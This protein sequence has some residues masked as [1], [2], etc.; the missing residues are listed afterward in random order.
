MAEQAERSAWFIA[1]ARPDRPLPRTA[2]PL[3]REKATDVCSAASARSQHM[4]RNRL[5]AGPL[6]ALEIFL[7][8]PRPGL[9]RWTFSTLARRLGR[10]VLAELHHDGSCVLA[11]NLSWRALPREDEP[12][13]QTTELLVSADA[14]GA[15]CRDTFTLAQE[16]GRHLGVDSTLTVT[17]GIAAAEVAPLTPVITDYG[18]LREIAEDARR[19]RRIQPVTSLISPADEDDLLQA[20]TQ[21]MFTD[22]IHQFG[23]NAYL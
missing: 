8:Y 22:L 2:P 14:V 16:L 23:I 19:P 1:V 15:C 6:R 20:R 10:E 11:V 5:V 3:A 12:T 7:P 17:A 9:R 4:T 13:P 21:E 18:G